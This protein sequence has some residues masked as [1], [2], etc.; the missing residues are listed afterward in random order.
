[1]H[2]GGLLRDSIALVVP[3]AAP[4]GI[5]IILHE[6]LCDLYV[7]TDR[8]RCRQV[9]LN[10]LSNAVK[11]NHD[12]GVVDIVCTQ[13][14]DATLRIAVCDTGPGI[15]P[16]RQ[17]RL[18]QPFDRLDAEQTG[19]QGTGLGL[20]LTRQLVEHLG[21]NIGLDSTPGQ[22]ATFWVDLPLTDAPAGLADQGPAP[23]VVGTA[24][25]HQILLVEDN[26]ANL[27]VVETMLNRK[28][29]DVSVL[30]AMQGTIALE[31]AYEHRPTMVLLD[32]HL[33]DMPG[34]DVLARLQADHR[35]RDIPVV[36]AS[37]DA[38][39]GRMRQLREDGAF[40][41]VAKPFDMQRFLQVIDA[42]IA[43]SPQ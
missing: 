21:G 6:G 34:R 37:A 35:T 15:D 33:P 8:Q 16:A 29:P 24:T 2:A 41:Y 17:H 18:F 36:I 28:R 38:T 13:P 32:L 31:L 23:P 30:P 1:M 3:L 11:Y 40:D 12:H 39:P 27:R 4:R 14:N 42:A 22:G 20:A 9:L 26:L 10:L 5:R 7:H 25:A 19:V 43:A